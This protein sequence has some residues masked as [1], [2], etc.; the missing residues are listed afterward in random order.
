MFYID[1]RVAVAPCRD[2]TVVIKRREPAASSHVVLL[3]HLEGRR[4]VILFPVNTSS[5]TSSRAVLIPNVIHQEARLMPLAIVN[6]VVDAPEVSVNTTF[7]E[8]LLTCTR[9]P[10]KYSTKTSPLLPCW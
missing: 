1:R 2:V 4:V 3:L 9:L 6:R 10:S 8:L 7:G 5:Q